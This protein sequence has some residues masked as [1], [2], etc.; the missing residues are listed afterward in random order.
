MT[1]KI[2]VR[3]I[4]F[5]LLAYTAV[6]KFILYPTVLSFQSGRDLLFSALIDFLVQGVIIWAVSYLCS[7]TEKTLFELIE[8]T[9]GNI[10]AR[11]IYGLFA[12]F[13]IVCTIVPLFEQKVY[14]HAIFYDTIP[15]LGAFVPFFFFAVY[16]A[17][18]GFQNIGRS[19]DICLPIF[20]LSMLFILGMSVLEVK[21]DNFLPILKTPLK[22][23]AGASLGTMFRFFEPCWLLMFM[24][25][26]KYKKGDAAKITLSYVGGAL[27][28]ILILA[29]FYGVYGDISASRQFAISKI[30]LFFP[31]IETVG[32]IDLIALYALEI[33]M[34]FALVLNLQLAVHCISKCTGY[35]NSP[36]YSL[37]INAGLLLMLIFLDNKFNDIHTF[38]SSWM[39]I[40]F[41]IF[42]NIIPLLSWALRR[43]R[44]RD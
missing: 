18:K 3:Q 32:R 16:A 22:D 11:I 19:A 2:S 25:H 27:F 41:L 35:D 31:A 6:S 29:V 39:W 20:L 7:R 36:L 9:L 43:R 26:F 30:S 13:F 34:L 4:C 42:A 38:W 5:I 24:G 17:S 8:D 40:V 21:W 37:I 33:V 10:T 12:L 15:S 23:V 1:N 28:V 14:V 44:A